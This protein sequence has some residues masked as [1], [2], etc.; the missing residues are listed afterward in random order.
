M[1]YDLECIMIDRT[2]V[3]EGFCTVVFGCRKCECGKI[4]KG[5]KESGVLCGV[6]DSVST[7][8]KLCVQVKVEGLFCCELKQRYKGAGR[9][10][11]Y[12]TSWG[13]E[14]VKLEGKLTVGCNWWV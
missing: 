4:R 7:R 14:G 5:R 10:R 6:V 2:S 3:R 12:L 13:G 8:Y 9:D 11:V 1:Q